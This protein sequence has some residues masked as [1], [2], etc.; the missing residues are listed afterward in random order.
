MIAE[1]ER[2]D[3]ECEVY[4]SLSTRYYD[5]RVEHAKLEESAKRSKWLEVLSFVA[6]SVGAAGIG[7]AP[8]YLADKNLHATGIFVLSCSIVLVLTGVVSKVM[9]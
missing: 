9:K 5:L 2:L 6:S 1:I 3:S 7:A 8:S 4:R